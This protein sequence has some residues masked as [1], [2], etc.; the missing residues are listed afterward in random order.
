MP[1][2]MGRRDLRKLAS[3]AQQGIDGMIDAGREASGN[4]GFVPERLSFQSTGV[5]KKAN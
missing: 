3:P 4:R 2:G 1:P 5:S